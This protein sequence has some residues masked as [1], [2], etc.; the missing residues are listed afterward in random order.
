MTDKILEE[1]SEE[2][3]KL[4]DD[5]EDN[6]DVEYSLHNKEFNESNKKK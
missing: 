3:T 2:L 4:M 5:I 1:M 6:I